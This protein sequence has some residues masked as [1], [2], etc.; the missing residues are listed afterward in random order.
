MMSQQSL[1]HSV[2]VHKLRDAKSISGLSM[3]D[4]HLVVP[5]QQTPSLPFTLF[6]LS[7]FASLLCHAFAPHK[8]TVTATRSV[9]YKYYSW[10]QLTTWD[11]Q[12]VSTTRFL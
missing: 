8:D 6:T 2:F 11:K 7:V 1:G 9:S 10:L 12:P 3:R 5:R 4:A